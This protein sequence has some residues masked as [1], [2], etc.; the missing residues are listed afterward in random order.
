VA[1]ARAAA[2]LI[3]AGPWERRRTEVPQL[4]NLLP[5]QDLDLRIEACRAR[6]LEIPKQKGK[7]EVQKKRLQGELG[8]REQVVMQLQLEQRD[9]EGEVAQ[10]QAQIKKYEQQ[11][12]AVKKNEEY[13]ALLHEIE[14][15][16]KQIGVK[17]ERIIALLMEID[18]AKGRLAEDRK[19]IEAELKQIDRQCAEIDEELANA[20]AARKELEAQRAPLMGR[21]DPAL[22][23]RYNRIRASKKTGAA[24]VTLNGATCSGCHMM[25]TA[26]VVN[27]VLAG[28]TH[29]CA[30][31]GRLLY[32]PD[33]VAA[34]QTG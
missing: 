30:H 27:E 14:M 5:L 28:R 13:Q 15:L 29:T 6:E 33:A 2:F 24:A 11:L 3:L 16:K 25:V 8:E 18:E 32:A 34:Q 10:K 12:F 1:A 19:R 31:C 4:K 20:V 22:L 21:V 26:Q 23:A 9:C 17:E 7:F